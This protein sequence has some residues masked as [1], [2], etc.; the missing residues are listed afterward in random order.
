MCNREFWTIEYSILRT[1]K[2]G[3]ILSIVFF[4]K[5]RNINSKKEVILP[6]TRSRLVAKFQ[7]R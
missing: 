1:Q 4:K 5:A 7:T 2:K 6:Y 3:I